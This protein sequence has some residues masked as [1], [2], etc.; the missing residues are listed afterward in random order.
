MQDVNW[1]EHPSSG[2]G[3]A[4]DRGRISGY[5]VISKAIQ[6]FLEETNVFCK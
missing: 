1:L 5:I 4:C 6:K 3:E 2:S